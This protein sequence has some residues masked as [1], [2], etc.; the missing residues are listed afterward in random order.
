MYCSER[1]CFHLKWPLLAYARQSNTKVILKQ[2]NMMGNTFFISLKSSK[3]RLRN[4]YLEITETELHYCAAQS[5]NTA[6]LL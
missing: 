5:S 2:S 6:F 3:E 4:M 1:F